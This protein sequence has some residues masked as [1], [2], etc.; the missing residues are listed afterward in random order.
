[1]TQTQKKRVRG[2]EV[3]LLPVNEAHGVD[4]VQSENNLGRVKASPLLW[5]VVVAHQVYQ[6]STG[7]VLH[8]HIEVAV[9]LECKEELWNG[10][11]IT[12]EEKS[13]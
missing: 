8:H 1:M 13:T 5:D 2:A 11:E 7:H 10:E 4:S 12:N 6:V 9:I 3:L